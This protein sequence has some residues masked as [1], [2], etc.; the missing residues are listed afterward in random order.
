MSTVPSSDRRLRVRRPDH[1]DSP[2][3]EAMHGYL[4]SFAEFFFPDA[5][6]DIDWDAGYES[7]DT[8]L[9]QIAGKTRVSVMRADSLFRVKRR[10]GAQQLVLIHGEVQT[11]RDAK[12]AERMF[13]YNY[14]SFDAQGL[15]VASFAILGDSSRRWRPD[16][17]GWSLW[18]C[19]MGIRFPVVKLIDWEGREEELLASRNPF[20]LITHAFLSTRAT[21]DDAELRRIFKLRIVRRLYEQSYTAEDVRKLFRVIDWM[22]ELG[23]EQAIIFRTELEELEEETGMKYVTSIERMYL[24][25]ARQ[26]GRREIQ[27]GLVSLLM[28]QL[29]QRFGQLPEWADQKLRSATPETLESWGRRIL[30]ARSLEE[31]FA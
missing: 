11:T 23:E 31:V 6:A 2:W 5:Y 25:E 20:A 10:S 3:R 15:E 30:G 22:M 29:A 4:P 18:G 12:L 14:R 17:Y 16:R 19:E 21:R 26:E 24:Q 8:E 7:L 27:Q 1:F 9:R 13:R 28:T